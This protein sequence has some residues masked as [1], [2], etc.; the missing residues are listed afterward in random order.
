MNPNGRDK[1]Y[2]FLVVVKSQLQLADAPIRLSREA[3]TDHAALLIEAEGTN[4][5]T[6]YQQAKQIY[7]EV[8]EA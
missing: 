4:P 7:R 5:H 8:F 2:H 6:A 3:I 1:A